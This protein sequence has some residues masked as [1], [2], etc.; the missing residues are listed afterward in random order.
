[1]I[2]GGPIGLASAIAASRAGYKKVILVDQTSSF[3][4]SGDFMNVNPNGIRALRTFS[5]DVADAIVAAHRAENEEFKMRDASGT[6]YETPDIGDVDGI[7]NVGSSWYFVQKLLLDTVETMPDTIRVETNTQFVEFEEDND[8]DVVTAKFVVDR[9]RKNPFAHWGNDPN[10]TTYE[11][12]TGA[13]GT[14]IDTDVAPAAEGE[15]N[16]LSVPKE[17]RIQARCVFACDGMNSKAREEVYRLHGKRIDGAKAHYSGFVSLKGTVGTDVVLSPQLEKEVEEL[18]VEEDK[19]GQKQGI[20]M[21]GG[22]SDDP[23]M[24]TMMVLRLQGDFSKRLGMSWRFICHAVVDENVANTRDPLQI[25][26]V[27]LEQLERHGFPSCLRQLFKE[28]IEQEEAKVL[29]RPLH[30]V[31]VSYP[32]NFPV[33]SKSTIPMEMDRNEN[34]N[35]PFGHGR[36]FL[37]GDSL[38][39]MPP[40]LSLGTSTGFE[41]VAELIPLLFNNNTDDSNSNIDY[42]EVQKK[43]VEVR[44]ERI[45]NAQRESLARRWAHDQEKYARNLRNIRHF[46]PL[47]TTR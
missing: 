47:N 33:A 34:R 21:A 29:V 26:P 36:I 25:L 6:P 35:C 31:P 1:M 11:A 46:V 38:H 3:R 7:P 14:V 16:T 30:I 4:K 5:R 9:V 24:P 39:G 41:D 22:P 19:D 17:V 45:E 32:P 27:A 2:G 20:C 42:E 8:N 18:Y 15:G 12:P 43:Y 44:W 37:V 10:A 28:V 23:D 40:F 13:P